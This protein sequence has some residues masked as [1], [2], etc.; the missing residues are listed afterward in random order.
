VDDDTNRP[1]VATSLLLLRHRDVDLALA[2]LYALPAL[3]FL[4]A[5]WP[6]AGVQHDMD[7]LLGAFCAISAAVW[8][9]SRM[10]RSPF[11]AWIVLPMCT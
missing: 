2:L 5:W 11:Q 4:V 8:L 1:A 7:L 3:V 6:S 9:A 10:P